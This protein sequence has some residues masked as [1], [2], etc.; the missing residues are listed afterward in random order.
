MN[1]RELIQSGMVNFPM[2]AETN[3]HEG[4][5]YVR[6]YVMDTDDGIGECCGVNTFEEFQDV[7]VGSDVTKAAQI[8]AEALIREQWFVEDLSIEAKPHADR[9]VEE[10]AKMNKVFEDRFKMEETLTQESRAAVCTLNA[11]GYQASHALVANILMGSTGWSGSNK[12]GEIY[13]IC[14]YQDLTS[15]GKAV[16]DMMQKAYPTCKLALM[17]FLDT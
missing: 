15:D 7:F 4:G 10:L 1:R 6:L 9:S 2:S 11:H 3:T 8:A 13:F 16:Y 5:M 12:T 17:T 14:E